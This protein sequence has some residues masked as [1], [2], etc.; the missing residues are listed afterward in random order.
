VDG[1]FDKLL[2]AIVRATIKALSEPGVLAGLVDS[3]LSV[4]RE[5]QIKASG[6]NDEDKMFI[7]GAHADG[8]VAK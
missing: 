4:T 2:A 3:W 1:F 8:W 7:D 6:V 5:R